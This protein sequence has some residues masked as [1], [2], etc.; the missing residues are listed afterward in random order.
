MLTF[1][2]TYQPQT[3]DTIQIRLLM[4][5]MPVSAGLML[6]IRPHGHLALLVIVFSWT[7]NVAKWTWWPVK[8]RCVPF[9]T[10][11]AGGQQLSGLAAE[12]VAAYITRMRRI[13][14]MLCR[15]NLQQLRRVRLHVCRPESHTQNDAVR[16]TAYTDAAV[17]ALALHIF[18]SFC[19]PEQPLCWLILF[20]SLVLISLN[21]FFY[22]E[23][24]KVPHV[25]RPALTDNKP[26]F[27]GGHIQED[28]KDQTTM[29]NPHYLTY[30]LN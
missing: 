10:Q 5:G 8:G 22:S 19:L 2:V 13:L 18:H 11:A 29:T 3:C 9:D 23:N 20:S 26:G 30:T 1:L 17:C 24:I 15:S 12:V 21:L 6:N 4:L 28:L 16:L 14:L 7:P 25:S 27:F